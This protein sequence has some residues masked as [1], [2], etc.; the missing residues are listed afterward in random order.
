MLALI[1]PLWYLACEHYLAVLPAHGCA[2]PEMLLQHITA[3]T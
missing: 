1:Y 2:L 3:N